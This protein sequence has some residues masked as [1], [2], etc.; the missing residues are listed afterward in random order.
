M[1]EASTATTL[2]RDSRDIRKF[3]VLS[4]QLAGVFLI[5]KVYRIEMPAFLLLSAICFA[6]FGIH[7][8]LAFRFKK[9]FFVV[10]SMAA[11]FAV[12]EPRTAALLNGAGLAFYG[13]LRL[14]VAY[15]LRLGA[16][17]VIGAVLLAGRSRGLGGLVP[18]QFWPVFG[19][20]F[21]F[22]MMVYLYDLRYARDRPALLDYLGYFFIIPNY[23]F[24]LFPVIDFQTFRRSY[25]NTDFHDIAQTGV[26][27]IVRGT[28]HLLLYRVVYHTRS[29]PDP[30]LVDSLG[31]LL[32][33]MFMTYLLYL[34]VSG[35]FHIAVGMLHLFGFNLPETNRRYLLASSI[36]DFWRRINIYWKDFIVKMVYFPVFFRLRRRGEVLATCVATVAA[37]VLTWALHSYQWYWL[38]GDLLL[39]A[40]DALF[41]A[42]LGGL[43]M[44]T[45]L[46]EMR[47]RKRRARP[48]PG[49]RVAV[50]RVLCVAGTLATVTVLWSLWNS[51]SVSEWLDL[52]TYWRAS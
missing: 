39:S 1:A 44:V 30:A 28:V 17:V 33:T 49:K 11:G 9:P 21:M 41:W 19:A 29:E 22:R 23:Y 7:Y 32:A 36:T 31:K 3:L 51:G 16:M 20:I 18:E 6:G 43:V 14:P 15:R 8:W 37:F 10:L 26:R 24:L 42:L 52:L 48:A 12:L 35:Q 25:F 27:W 40:P 4:C 47:F 2:A 46:Y 13:L 38:Q 34:R 5:F 45:V 50:G